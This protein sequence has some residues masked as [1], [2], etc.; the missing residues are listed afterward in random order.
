MIRKKNRFLFFTVLII[1]IVA[2]L[3]Y[4]FHQQKKDLVLV[5]VKTISSSYGWGY[6]IIADGKVYIHQEFI[7]AIPGKHGFKSSEDAEKVGRKVVTKISAGQLPPTITVEELKEMG[8]V[9]DSA[10]SK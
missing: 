9:K 10:A 7:P 6:E 8:I 2:I 4:H 3:Y 1:A 5:E